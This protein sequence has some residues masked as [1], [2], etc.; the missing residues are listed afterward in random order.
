MIERLTHPGDHVHDSEPRL[1]FKPKPHDLEPVQERPAAET[2]SCPMLAAPGTLSALATH[3]LP[4]LGLA[5]SVGEDNGALQ[6][7]VS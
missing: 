1:L 6:R 5:A 7:Q 3:P 2:A 4:Y